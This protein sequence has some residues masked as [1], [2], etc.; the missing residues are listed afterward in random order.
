M[1]INEIADKFGITERLESFSPGWE[2]SI[3]A[4]PA[5]I[6]DFLKP[7]TFITS[8]RFCGFASDIEP[9][10]VSTAEQIC[11]DNALLHLCW[12]YFHQ[13]TD[14]T[15]PV[16]YN[17]CPD[18]KKPLGDK[19]GIF[20]LLVGLGVVPGA[21]AVYGK[22]NVPENIIRDTMREIE[23]FNENHK[24]ACKL[25]G[26]LINQI[27]WLG[28]YYK[29][30]LFRLG[31]MEY[32]IEPFNY[33]RFFYRNRKTGLKICFAPDNVRYNGEG[34]VDGTDGIIDAENG[35]TSSF[36]EENGII[37]GNPISP[38]GHALNKR[39][40]ISLKEWEPALRPNDWVIDLHIPP[41]GGMTPEACLESFKA[42]FDFFNTRFPEKKSSAIV[43]SS[44][45]F[46]TQ[47]ETYLPDS[48]MVKFMRE[49]YLF[50]VQSSGNDGMFFVF[51]RDFKDLSEAPRET[52]LQK[53]MMDIL[54]SGRKLRSS[55]MAFFIED[56]KYFGTGHYRKS[57]DEMES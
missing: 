27:S 44:W 15:H 23:G 25:P 42:A 50:P 11:G 1:N 28:N 31:R 51:C 32:K 10:L 22:M 49:L 18:L 41:G 37:C 53:A 39:L 19:F 5:G 48:N 54:E 7:E 20:Y 40:Q 43:C 21:R 4:M 29:G 36:Y 26:L 8:A 47:F 14:G 13:L 45:I 52:R 16:N 6:P 57:W 24:I 17:K 46:N 2:E 9:T 38:Y 55:G 33:H 12:H 56:L 34:F 30:K 3:A 35:W